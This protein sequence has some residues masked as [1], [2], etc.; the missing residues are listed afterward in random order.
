MVNPIP[1]E[2]KFACLEAL[3]YFE[4]RE[5]A[6]T[7]SGHWQGNK[8]MHHATALRDAL[9]NAGVKVDE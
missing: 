3:E 4:Q 1:D 6:S 9:R 7:D 2:L 5:D 8:E